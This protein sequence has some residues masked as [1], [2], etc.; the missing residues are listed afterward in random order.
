MKYSYLLL[1]SF[2]WGMYYIFNK[3]AVQYA[4]VFTVGIFIRV[5]VF[6]ILCF[7][8]FFRKRIKEL[9]IIKVAF[10]E[11]FLI[12]FL[13]FLLDIF[14][15]LGLNYSTA[16]N[17]S[18]LLKSDIFFT[19]IISLFLGLRF[20]SFDLFGSISM[21]LGILLVLNV[22]FANLSFNF[23]DIFFILS[24]LFISLNAFLI[25]YVQ[26]KYKI[27]N[28]IIAFY[29]NFFAMLFFIFISYKFSNRFFE[30]K[31]TIF[32]LLAGICQFLIYILYYYNLHKFPIWI[33]R[34]FLLFTPVFVTIIGTLFLNEKMIFVQI[35]G[36]FL[37]LF[38]GF[39]IILKQKGVKS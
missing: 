16:S 34:T 35:I 24:A 20:T 30:F 2:V 4:D 31:G 36:I 12:G 11:L 6:I 3:I 8:L 33:V 39:I 32:L 26:K 28:M 38:G 19:D 25:I 18:L 10:K 37:I 1:L 7:I 13:G 22:D 9:K 5:L 14:A 21:I 23:G 29:N 27:K 15:F 17:G